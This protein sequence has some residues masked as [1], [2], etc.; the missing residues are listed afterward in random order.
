MTE[1]PEEGPFLTLN[2]ETHCYEHECEVEIRIRVT[3]RTKVDP[4]RFRGVL[5]RALEEDEAADLT[6][7]KEYQRITR[8]IL[9]ASFW[10]GKSTAE[11]TYDPPLPPGAMV[12]PLSS[13]PIL[14]H[15]PTFAEQRKAYME[16]RT[17]H[18]PPHLWLEECLTPLLPPSASQKQRDERY[19]LR[20]EEK[21]LLKRFRTAWEKGNYPLDSA[22]EEEERL[23][24]ENNHHADPIERLEAIAKVLNENSFD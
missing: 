11:V 7:P 9:K 20:D 13:V 16:E 22:A 1:R 12:V 4:E 6:D 2:P 18:V 10:E 8:R 23:Y 3:K 14:E 24:Q 21:K 19:Y 5:L 15:T 17:R